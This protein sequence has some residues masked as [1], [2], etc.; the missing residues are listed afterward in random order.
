MLKILL[1]V[2]LSVSLYGETASVEDLEQKAQNVSISLRQLCAIPHYDIYTGLESAYYFQLMAKTERMFYKIDTANHIN[3]LS[4][5]MMN[6]ADRDTLQ[7]DIEQKMWML[8]KDMP[9]IQ[10][11][12]DCFRRGL[13]NSNKKTIP[14]ECFKACDD[15]NELIKEVNNYPTPDFDNAKEK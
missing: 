13:V 8:K 10:D 4:A 5:M 15:Y 2:I 1:L 7:L 9:P 12:V 3:M 11:M 14:M 6:S